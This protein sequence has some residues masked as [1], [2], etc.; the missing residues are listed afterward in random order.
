MQTDV[1][2]YDMDKKQGSVMDSNPPTRGNSRREKQ[3]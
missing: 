2:A 1:A 3:S